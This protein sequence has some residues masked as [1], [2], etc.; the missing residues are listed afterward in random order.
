M[1]VYEKIV[2]DIESGDVVEEVSYHTDQSPALC[3]FGTDVQ[4]PAP[5]QKDATQTQLEQAQLDALKK[6]NMY[7]E[8]T[9]PV[10]L[11]NA[12]YKMVTN[13]DG[14]MALQK[15]STD[16]YL[17]TLSTA[18]KALYT[19]QLAAAGL[20]TGGN[21]LTE[22][23]YLATLTPAEKLK[24]QVEQ[25]AYNRSLKAINGEL[26][27]SP[28]LETELSKQRDTLVNTLSSKLGPDWQLSTPGIKAIQEF[29]ARATDLREEARRG[30]MTTAEGI[31]TAQTSNNIKDVTKNLTLGNYLSTLG[32]DT[33][34]KLYSVPKAY[35]SL[36]G[37]YGSVISPYQNERM[38]VYGNNV[39]SA[40]QSSANKASLY[41]SLIKGGSSAYGAYAASPYEM[42]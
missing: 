12:G 22:D 2:I 11:A 5:Q 33:A 27:V 23:Q 21:T 31:A 16:E 29:D 17:G 19:K 18:D 35:Q 20:D 39:A 15:M 25:A 3:D 7:T 26:D 6:E 40:M 13:A 24:Y 41:G 8:L 28:A 30:M 9:T 38:T 14:S 34:N 4:A 32:D 36:I 1:K 10:S 37:T 42:F